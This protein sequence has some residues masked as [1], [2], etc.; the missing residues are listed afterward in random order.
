VIIPQARQ[1]CKEGL[2]R[3]ETRFLKQVTIRNLK[4]FKIGLNRPYLFGGFSVNIDRKGDISSPPKGG[5]VIGRRLAY[6]PVGGTK[7][8]TTQV[9]TTTITKEVR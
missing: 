3:T 9:L 7:V 8:P 1:K 5:E 6:P 2:G 4:I